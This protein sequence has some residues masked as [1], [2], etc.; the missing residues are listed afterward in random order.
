MIK[1][2]LQA[3]IPAPLGSPLTGYLLHFHIYDKNR[4]IQIRLNNTSTSYML[5]NV[6]ACTFNITLRLAALSQTGPSRNNRS[7]RLGTYAVRFTYHLLSHSLFVENPIY[8]DVSHYIYISLIPRPIST[9][10]LLLTQWVG[11]W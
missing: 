3:P 6:T 8:K 9:Q 7:V 1:F 4:T 5:S 11:T 10:L 2:L